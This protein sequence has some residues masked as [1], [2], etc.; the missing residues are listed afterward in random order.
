[1]DKNKFTLIFDA[2]SA[3][4]SF[5][6]NVVASFCLQLNPTIDW[7][8]DVKTAVSEAVT[9]C[10][11]H[12]YNLN[13]GEILLNAQ[14]IENSVHIDI[15]D[16]GIGIDNIDDAVKPF[17]TTKPDDERS[18]MGFTIMETFMD[19][20]KVLKNESGGTTVKLVK[21]F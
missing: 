7:L 9:N 16:F 18:G 12:A 13:D 1:M 20:M 17:Y 2:N 15:V 21:N 14:I 4:E 6:R 5:S 19:E 8:G 3:N 11:V 10:I